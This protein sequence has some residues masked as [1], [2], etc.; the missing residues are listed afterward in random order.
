MTTRRDF[1][2]FIGLGAAALA[3]P[4]KAAMP[5]PGLRPIRQPLYD[6]HTITAGPVFS[7]YKSIVA[8]LDALPKSGGV[9]F[10]REGTYESGAV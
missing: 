4:V 8:A 10:V 2:R 1:L 7:D 9:I 3:I 5:L 6:A